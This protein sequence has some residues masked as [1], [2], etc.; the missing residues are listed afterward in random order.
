MVQKITVELTD[1]T[2]GSPADETVTFALDGTTYEIDLST[3]H[4]STIRADLSTWIA[5][6]RKAPKTHQPRQTKPARSA[7][8]TT[9]IR[10]W[11]RQNG[12]A[13]SDRGRISGQVAAAYAAAH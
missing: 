12:L 13:V 8:D 2:D 3:A 6:A 10:D 5:A 7:A 9:A 1:D 11:A 4:A